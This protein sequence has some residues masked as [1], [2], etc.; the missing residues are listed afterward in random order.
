MNIK[1][2]TTIIFFLV[3]GLLQ[4]LL[5]SACFALSDEKVLNLQT[6]L[7]G[8]PTGERIANFAE[9]FL[10]VPYDIDPLGTYVTH[11]VIIADEQVDCMYLVF[12]A[13]EL[14]LSSTPA[15]AVQVA[16]NKRFHTKGVLAGGKVVNYNDRFAYGEDMIY[17]G[18][19]GNEITAE[20]GET[21][22]I[23]DLR[24]GQSVPML[25]RD[26]A[27][28]EIS[29][30]RSGDILFFIK[31]PQKT[32]SDEIVGHIGVISAT[33]PTRQRYLSDS[34]KRKKRQKRHRQKK[35]VGRLFKKDA[36]HRSK[37]NPVSIGTLLSYPVS[38]YRLLEALVCLRSFLCLCLRIFFLRHFTTLPTH[39]PPF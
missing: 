5:N 14:A 34:R 37:N 28:K 32:V 3:C 24:S 39:S 31:A 36:F 33:G 35:R 27:L 21:V 22:A 23:K 13:V 4:V 38:F 9:Q 18:K 2:K 26:E 15:D 30:L 11:K 8:K 10:G 17:S 29:K 16:L 19:W 6:E 7:K 1:V 25:P 12:R 20:I